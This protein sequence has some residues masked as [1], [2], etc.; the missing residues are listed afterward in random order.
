ML[1]QKKQWVLK[2]KELLSGDILISYLLRDRGVP[3]KSEECF[4]SPNF[5][6]DL[7]DPYLFRDMK[8]AVERVLIAAENNEKVLIYGDYDVD[9][10]TSSI[11]LYKLL[12]A[13][14][15]NAEVYLPHRENEGYGMNKDVVKRFAEKGFSLVVSSDCGISNFDEI[16]LANKSGMDVIIFDH[17]LP[18]EKIPAAYAIINPKLP[19]EA[20]PFKELSS[21]GVVFKFIQAFF[22]NE[23]AKKIAQDKGLDR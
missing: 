20:Y 5:E 19:E 13:L 22:K 10:V 1:K 2:N 12:F 16:D 18:P 17:H 11:M 8:K 7:H 15:L 23:Q 4:F 9:G 6:R 14:G 3:D 21:G